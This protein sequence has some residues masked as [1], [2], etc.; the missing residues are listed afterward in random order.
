MIKINI[1]RRL[2]PG[3]LLAATSIGASHLVLSPQAG[4]LFGYQ[5]LWL[6][7]AAHLIKYPAFEFGPRYAAATGTSLLA[8]YTRLPGPKNW[9]LWLFL[10][11]TVLQGIGV[12]AG[13]VS[14]SGAVLTTWTGLLNAELFSVGV[15]AL[16]VGML[17]A[18]GFAWLDHLNKIMM[19]GLALATFLAFVPVFPSP[20]D[21]SGLLVPCIPEGSLVLVAAILGWMPTGI[22]VSV[23]HS[24]WTLEKLKRLGLDP[25]CEEGGSVDAQC[26]QLKL[27]LSD[28]R[29]GYGLSLATGIMFVTMGAVHLVGQGEALKGVGFIE[30]L[31]SAYTNVLGRWMYH[32]FMLTALFAMF[33][34]TYTV[35]DGF[36]RSF[37]EVLGGLRPAWATGKPRRRTYAGFV[38]VSALLAAVTLV[39][40]GNPVRLVLVVALISLAVAPV[41]Y[42]LNLICVGR[43]ISEPRLRP[44]RITVWLGWIGV[45]VMLLAVGVT[46]YVKLIA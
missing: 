20:A 34:T 26:E 46:V 29:V 23:W 4:A 6:V 18:G 37:A 7:L 24:F 35:I 15:L 9:A 45:A 8:G 31:S 2:G 17:F 16:V 44:S 14:I 42:A 13:V 21:L 38:L 39:S 19:A 3:I 25:A 32:V 27:S 36:S 33:S 40:V 43:H 12:L 30:A 1:W 28:M 41:L 22:D 10:A 5:L 11:S